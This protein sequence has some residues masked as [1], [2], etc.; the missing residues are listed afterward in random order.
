MIRNRNH[1]LLLAGMLLTAAMFTACSDDDKYGSED[2]VR[3]VDTRFTFALPQRIVGSLP[4][5][6]ET[7]MSADVVQLEGTSETF[8]GL[9]GIHLLSFD[10]EPGLQSKS[11][12]EIAYL[13]G[14]KGRLIELATNNDYSVACHVKVPMGTTHFAF[15]AH[16]VDGGDTPEDRFRYGALSVSGLDDYTGNDGISFEPVPICTSEA[17]Q[18]GSAAGQALVDLLNTLMSTTGPEAAPNDRWSTAVDQNLRESWRGMTELKT[19]SS[20]SVERVLGSVYFLVSI[21]LAG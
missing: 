18:G 13:N 11:N 1:K 4:Q 15:Y 20:A 10:S 5:S 3:T 7:R 2:M 9:D 14:T 12:G 8:R 19:L 17:N 21:V 6:P 16:A